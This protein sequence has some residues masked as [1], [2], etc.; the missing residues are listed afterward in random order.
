MRPMSR[1]VHALIFAALL[2]GTSSCN[3]ETEARGGVSP[4]QQASTGAGIPDL[5]LALSNNAVARVEVDGEYRLYSFLGLGEGKRWQDISR[6]AF[7]YHQGETAWRPLPQPPIGE[8]RLASVAAAV[9][10]KVFLFGGYTVAADGHE[11]STPEVLRLDP[12]TGAW[13]RMAAMPVPVDDSVALVLHDRYIV[14]VSGWHQDR[15]VDRV[16]FYDAAGDRWFD[17]TPFPGT[18]VFGHA[19]AILGDVA[20][21]CDG[22]ALD[23]SGGKRRFHASDEC[24][25]GDFDL[26]D[27]GTITWTRIEPHPG[28]PRYRM[29][30]AADAAHSRLLFAGGSENPYNFNGIGYD[31]VAA[32]ASSA[33]DAYDPVT[34][35]WTRLPALAE[36]SMDHRGLLP[37]EGGFVLIGGMRDPQRVVAAVQ[38]YGS[39]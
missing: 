38:H 22:V 26:E 14:L 8:G 1:C 12:R 17:G 28:K 39:P 16:Q 11:T 19:A 30:A 31:G 34:G 23:A 27:A 9:D 36:P 25:R 37:V 6:R 7:E 32:P 18:P 24:W 13:A 15:N 3:H 21:V 10:G 33:V 2:L 4:A 5:P 20:V 35:A 29:G